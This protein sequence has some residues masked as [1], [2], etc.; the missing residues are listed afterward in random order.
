MTNPAHEEGLALLRAGDFERGIARLED[1]LKQ[2]PNRGQL[3]A[4]LALARSDAE[5][6]LLSAA[7]AERS[8]GN[9][10]RA[11]ALY[12]RVLKINAASVRARQGSDEVVRER[13]HVD[14]VATARTLLAKGDT[15]GATARLRPVLAE[16]P[17]NRTARDL[18]R[19]IEARTVR[20]AM[21]PPALGP[22]YRKPVT[23]DFRDAALRTVFDAIAR[24]TGIN[25][26][27]DRDVKPD[28]RTT[29]L[30]RNTP[31]EDALDLILATNQLEKKVLNE[32]TLLIY[33]AT[34]QK[35]REYQDL[36]V[37]AFFIAGADVKQ[38]QALLQKLVKIREVFIDE[39]QRLVIVRD[40]PDAVRLAEK[41][42]ALHDL[43]EPEV[44]LELEVLE[45]RRT[46]LLDLGIQWP[47]QLTLT[48]LPGAGATLTLSEL[49]NLNSDRISAGIGSVIINLKKQDGD[50]NILANPRVRAKNREKAKIL[51]G[52]KVPVVTTTAGATGFVAQSVQYLEVGLKLEIEPDIYMEDEVAM[53]VS[54]EVSSVTREI[55]TSTGLLTYQVG[56]RTAST[57]LR[58]RDGE[59]Q[60]LAGLLSDEER[61]TGNRVPALGDI[62]LLGRLFGSQRDDRQKTEIVL[63]ITPRLIRGLARPDAQLAEFWS[64]TEASLRT[65]PLALGQATGAPQAALQQVQGSS[66]R[67]GSTSPAAPATMALRAPP[68]VKQGDTFT[69]EVLLQADAALR[70]VPM[71][72][73]YDKV[74][75]SLVKVDEGSAFKGQKDRPAI[76]SNIDTVQG[77]AYVGITQSVPAVIASGTSLVTLTFRAQAASPKAD[78]RIL[79]AQ[80]FPATGG[81][82]AI[83][84]PSVQSIAIQP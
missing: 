53:K 82:L 33:P 61:Q 3:R 16:N 51:I 49:R 14:A 17:G 20:S 52:D 57:S 73:E 58:L 38:T 40:T 76:S 9:L 78:V 81:P 48:P 2:D 41:L 79:S 8:I 21:S 5:T 37:K 23:L 31:L 70:G 32:N 1:A 25:Y 84:L 63:S 4:D 71:Q 15:D 77:R 35:L 10:D 12:D 50:V 72:V 68:T 47:D 62:P 39:K 59:T 66:P 36:V 28:A 34:P 11:A 19:E 67:P 44:M 6:R 74:A 83:T 45:V 24:T 46:R 7:T 26:Y 55:T 75:L 80:G 64:G 42:I 29:V 60:I 56:S 43:G 65:R 22:A 30:A 69:V 54:L 18:M 27:F 13:R